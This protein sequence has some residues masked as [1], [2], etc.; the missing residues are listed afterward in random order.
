MWNGGGAQ[1][2]AVV[3][4]GVVV[5]AVIVSVQP[6]SILKDL[7]A[8]FGAAGQVFFAGMVWK[9]SRE[10]FRFTKAVSDRQKQID[11]LPIRQGLVDEL[12]KLYDV[13]RPF[14]LSLQTINLSAAVARRMI[15]VFSPAVISL[16]EVYH[17]HMRELNS[18]IQT[19]E[20]AA[21]NP[22]L[23]DQLKEIKDARSKTVANVR[24]SWRNAMANI[25]DEMKLT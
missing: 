14:K 15:P 7:I 11:L 16:L 5:L 4:F 8:G 13:I 3:A 24:Q 17:D 2:T 20:I 25:N 10:Q 22:S 6:G 9:L 18:A 19:L 21:S 12:H 1:M 23:A